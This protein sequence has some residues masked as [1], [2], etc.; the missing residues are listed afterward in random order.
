MLNHVRIGWRSWLFVACSALA[1]GQG[2]AA[3]YA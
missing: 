2:P 1:I 3:A